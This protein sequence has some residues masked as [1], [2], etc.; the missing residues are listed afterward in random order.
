MKRLNESRNPFALSLPLLCISC[1]FSLDFIWLISPPVWPVLSR[2]SPTSPSSSLLF[3]FQQYSSPAE[4]S[5]V[6]STCITSSG[7]GS[8]RHEIMAF[9][10]RSKSSHSLMPSDLSSAQP[11]AIVILSSFS[12]GRS[13]AYATRFQH[14]I[15]WQHANCHGYG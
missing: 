6:V 14:R 9:C 12:F 11:L 4:S 13:F 7:D 1:F 2:F 3:S 15:R 10:V 5:S 8:V